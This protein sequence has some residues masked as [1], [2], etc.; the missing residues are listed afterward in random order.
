[1]VTVGDRQPIGTANVR[2]RRFLTRCHMEIQ[3]CL[4]S[5][6]GSADLRTRVILTR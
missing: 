2:D 6:S 1:L 5:R 4:G 3:A